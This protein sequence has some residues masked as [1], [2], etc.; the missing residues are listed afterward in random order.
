M[1]GL[2]IT[3]GL[4]LLLGALLLIAAEP[5]YAGKGNPGK[6]KDPPAWGQEKEKPNGGPKATGSQ[7]AN[8][9][10]VAKDPTQN[11]PITATET[12]TICHK[13]GTPAQHT[14]VIPAAALPGHL[15]HGDYEGPCQEATGTLTVTAMITLCHKP[16]T[17]A[18]KTLVLPAPAAWGHLQHGDYEGACEV[19][20]PT[21]PTNTQPVTATQMVTIC[22]KPGTPAQKTQVVPEAALSGHLQHGDEEGTCPDPPAASA[23]NH[24]R[25][26]Y[27]R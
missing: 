13:P 20:T 11:A 19:L 26:Q 5:S 9:A 12:V 4:A 21:V 6:H 23:A 10:P 1:K 16:G 22:H 8:R 17:P 14:L 25:W 3:L 7:K 15:R 27:P 2:G 24:R 18:Q